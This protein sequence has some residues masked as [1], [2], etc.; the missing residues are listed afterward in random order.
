MDI[1]FPKK[2]THKMDKKLIQNGHFFYQE[3]DTRKGQEIDTK[4]TFLFP[5][6]GQEIDTKWTFLFPRNGNYLSKKWTH[7]MD[8][9]CP[10]NGLKNN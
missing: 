10:R 7:E 8:I 1:S 9:S 2:W 4:W 3:M 6:N 5:R